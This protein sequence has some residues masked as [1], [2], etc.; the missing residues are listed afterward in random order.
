MRKGVVVWVP[1]NWCR[2]LS[3]SG[4]ELTSLEEG[5]IPQPVNLEPV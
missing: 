5:E 2:E 4:D 3:L 1:N